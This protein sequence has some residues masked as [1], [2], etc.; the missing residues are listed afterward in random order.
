M[1]CWHLVLI[2]GQSSPVVRSTTWSEFYSCDASILWQ[3]DHLRCNPDVFAG[4]ICGSICDA[5][6]PDSLACFS[7]ASASN[8]SKKRTKLNETKRKMPNGARRTEKSLFQVKEVWKRLFHDGDK[9]WSNTVTTFHLISFGYIQ[10][11]KNSGML[12][13]FETPK[14]WD[15][16]QHFFEILKCWV[17]CWPFTVANSASSTPWIP[18]AK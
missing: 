17:C 16:D 6:R 3:S 1:F 9:R 5:H 10:K 11:A 13:G 18:R 12:F 8:L 4:S 15:A 14:R 2:C 7:S